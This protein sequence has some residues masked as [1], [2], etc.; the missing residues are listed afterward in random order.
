[1]LPKSEGHI[2][3]KFSFEGVLQVI[4]QKLGGRGQGGYK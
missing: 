1:M 4:P 3:L 2:Y